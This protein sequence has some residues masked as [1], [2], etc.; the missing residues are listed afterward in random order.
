MRTGVNA[1]PASY[2]GRLFDAV[3]A[4]LG[5]GFDH[6]GHEGKAAAPLETLARDAADDGAYPFGL[7]QEGVPA[8]DPAPMWAALLGDLAHGAL[9]SAVAS[10]FHRG[11]AVAI[12]ELGAAAAPEADVVALSGGCLQNALLHRLLVDGFAAQGRQVLTQARVPANDG[13]LALGQAAI[14]A[15]RLMG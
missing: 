12:V 5:L 11:L 4:A 15:A 8:L 13:G 7:R 10:R 6:V 9:P 2:C 14:V 3:A 1:P